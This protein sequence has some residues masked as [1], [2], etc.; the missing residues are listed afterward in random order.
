MV[1]SHCMVYQIPPQSFEM[2]CIPPRMA[3]D[4]PTWQDVHGTIGDNA[5]VLVAGDNFLCCHWSD[6]YMNCFVYTAEMEAKAL[7]SSRIV[8]STL[9]QIGMLG[10]CAFNYY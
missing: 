9:Q 7:I 10:K 5:T 2:P 4:S 1:I 6:T 8:G 3:E